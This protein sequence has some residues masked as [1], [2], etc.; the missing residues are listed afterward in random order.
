[1]IGFQ[2]SAETFD[3]DNFSIVINLVFRL[4][5]FFQRLMNS[6]MMIIFTEFFENVF[7]LLNRGKDQIIQT[8]GFNSFHEAFCVSI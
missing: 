8:F 2:Q 7:K 3:A 5:D 4:D 1:M 6:F